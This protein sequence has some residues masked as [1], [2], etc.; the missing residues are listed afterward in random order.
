[1]LLKKHQ[2]EISAKILFSL[3]IPV[4]ATVFPET[5]GCEFDAAKAAA[6]ILTIFTQFFHQCF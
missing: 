2:T 5:G 1:V 4:L 6:I 3:Y